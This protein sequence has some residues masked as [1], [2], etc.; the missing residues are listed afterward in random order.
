MKLGRRVE[1]WK[2]GIGNGYSGNSKY[3]NDD[4]RFSDDIVYN[5]LQRLI[6]SSFIILITSDCF[7]EDGESHF[8]LELI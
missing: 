5:S 6:E 3:F 7:T 4:I 2:T 8:H 1:E